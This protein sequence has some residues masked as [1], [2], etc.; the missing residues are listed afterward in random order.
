MAKIL[1]IATVLGAAVLAGGGYAAAAGP[2][3][4]ASSSRGGANAAC[5]AASSLAVKFSD[6]TPQDEFA[7][8]LLGMGQI[9]SD[10]ARDVK[11]AHARSLGRAFSKLARATRRAAIAVDQGVG[12]DEAFADQ[13]RAAN[14]ARRAAKRLR[15]RRCVAYINEYF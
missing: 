13:T 4:D 15:T 7:T 10:L 9:T 12:A 1:V 3:G 6:A 14:T 11:A 8:W 2:S 5:R